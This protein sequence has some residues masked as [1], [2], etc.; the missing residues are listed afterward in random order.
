[1]VR[2]KKW[3]S[4]LCKYEVTGVEEFRYSIGFRQSLGFYNH[5]RRAVKDTQSGKPHLGFLLSISIKNII[6]SI[7]HLLF[8]FGKVLCGRSLR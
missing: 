5:N 8:T 6:L 7:L 3:V 1:M 2:N 4:I